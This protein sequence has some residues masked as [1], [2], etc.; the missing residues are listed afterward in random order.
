MAND[1][2]HRLKRVLVGR[3]IA[4]GRMRHELLPKRLALPVFSSDALSSV[5]YATEATLLVLLA[6]STAARGLLMPLSIAIAVL[7]AIVVSSYRQTVRVY[8]SAGGAYVVAKDNLGRLPSLVAAGALLTDYVLTVA[9]SI[10]AGVFALTSA[11]GGAQGMQLELAL[12]FL[13]LVAIANLRGVR[14]AGLLFAFPTYG[15][16]VVLSVMIVSGLVQCAG[17]GCPQAT[18]P[19]PEPVGSAVGAVGIVLILRAF[20]SGCAA[21]TGVEAIANGVTAFRPPQAQNA[22]RTLAIMGTIAI[23]LFLGVSFLAYQTD[24]QPSKTVSVVSEVARAVFPA[25]GSAGVLFYLV[26]GFTFAILVLAANTAFQG[27]PRVTALLAQDGFVPRQFANLGDR[28]VF[29]NGVLV[30]ALAA[31]TLLVAFRANVTALIHLYLVGVFTAFTL[32]QAGMV[33]LWARRGRAGEIRARNWRSSM[34]INAVGA[35]ATGLVTLLVIGT[36]FVEGAWMVIVAIPLLVAAFT[37]LRRRH[38]LV[39]RQ[40]QM[41]PAA[42]SDL[43]ESPVV[44]YV[45]SLDAATSEALAYVR[46]IR[47][48]RFRAIHVEATPAAGEGLQARWQAFSASAVKLELLPAAANPADAVVAYVEALKP[49]E[50]TLVTA[51]VPE[52]FTGR[53]IRQALRPSTA[54][55]LKTRLFGRPG[56]VVTDVSVVAR[57][58]TPQGLSPAP[59][60]AE[61]IVLVPRVD[62]ATA[63]AVAYAVSLNAQRTR[64]VFVALDRES[65]DVAKRDWEKWKLPVPLEVVDAPFR[66][67]EQPVLDEVRGITTDPNAL[68]A[69]VIPELAAPRWWQDLLHNERSLYLQWLLLFEPRVVLS[70]VPYPIR[71]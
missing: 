63:Q 10:A 41:H 5:A 27:F 32:S 54:F 68:A 64:A 24:A 22:A 69:V 15:F 45:D 62:A 65:A 48:E 67:L 39:E 21:L 18:V 1:A 9:V 70:R 13:A 31:A 52:P 50:G 60:R 51:V 4:T 29:S 7:L 12:A 35:L 40:V 37:T 46:A 2:F 33:R 71:L 44:L 47:G 3:P 34:V 6:S 42:M 8:S 58:E 26:Q 61:S 56:V 53:S 17:G 36:K 55:A 43:S 66:S 20:A 19:N 30:L 49:S 14:E 25:G 28:L 38:D 57:G 16:V 11:I 23:T 59:S